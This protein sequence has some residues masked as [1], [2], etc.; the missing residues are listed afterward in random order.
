MK[1]SCTSHLTELSAVEAEWAKDLVK[2]NSKFNQFEK[3]LLISAV[4]ICINQE[5]LAV[6]WS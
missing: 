2:V 6:D 5:I 3:L 4:F 1:L